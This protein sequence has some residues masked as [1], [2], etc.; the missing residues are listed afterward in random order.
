M[1]I[2]IIQ[3]EYDILVH[4]TIQYN[5]ILIQYPDEDS[6]TSKHVNQSQLITKCLISNKTTLYTARTAVELDIHQHLYS[7]NSNMVYHDINLHNN[8]NV[9]VTTLHDE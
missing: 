2:I 4:P 5:Y 6:H 7:Y 9:L 1:D 8:D 3:S